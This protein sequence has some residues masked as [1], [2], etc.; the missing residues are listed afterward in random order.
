MIRVDDGRQGL[1]GQ[2]AG[3]SLTENVPCAARFDID[4]GLAVTLEGQRSIVQIR[5]EDAR[6]PDIL[7]LGDELGAQVTRFFPAVLQ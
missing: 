2:G 4:N 3:D 7:S 1:T 6:R 5:G